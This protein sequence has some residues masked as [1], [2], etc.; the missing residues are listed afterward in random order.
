MAEAA[1]FRILVIG[2]SVGGL[3]VALELKRSTQA[4]IAVYERS[5]GTMEARGAGVVMQPDVE[6]LLK[7]HGIQAI[8]V[9]VRL[10]ERVAL[11]RDGSQD[12]Y[13]APQLMTAW[14]TLYKNLRRPLAGSCYRQDSL[15]R[16]LIIDD[17]E[18]TVVFEDGYETAG[19]F[20]VAADGVNSA[21]RAML[22]G[23]EA[24]AAYA[25]YVAWRGLEAEEDLPQHL[26]SKLSGCFTSYHADGMQFLCYLVPGADGSIAPGKRRVN[27]VWY[28]NT[29]ESDLPAILTGASGRTYES[30]LPPGDAAPAIESEL[31]DLA[32]LT[33]P[34]LF[35]DLVIGSTVFLQPVQ[36]VAPQKRLYG[37]AALIG[38]A[39]GTVRPH[40][41][42][43][44]SKAFADA[45]LLA[46]ALKD[47]NGDDV[48]PSDLL[49][50]WERQRDGDLHAIAKMGMKLAAGS[51][52]GI[53]S[54]SQPWNRPR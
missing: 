22:S 38:D 30:F 6:W 48:P 52:L 49:H 32:A 37:R 16:K 23:N 27:W 24:S 12:R 9:C 4:E 42:S 29:L 46:V 15:I 26:V 50:Y 40:T 11:A 7:Q 3:A 35:R 53:K 19:H 28:V 44:T 2:G 51:G 14:D 1:P 47:W 18:V 33:L 8:D 25:G 43:G 5:A 39:A 45:A 10:E 21:C 41:A 54:A 31:L 17:D 34:P 13:A 36:D 20:V